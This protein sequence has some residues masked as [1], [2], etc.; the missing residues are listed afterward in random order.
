MDERTANKLI[1]E[2]NR[3]KNA[4]I[5]FAKTCDWFDFHSNAATLFEYL[6]SVELSLLKRKLHQAIE[7]IPAALVLAIVIFSSV[8]ITASPLLM[9][10]REQIVLIAAAAILFELLLLFE[11]RL[12]VNI[13]T[14]NQQKNKDRFIRHIE[15]DFKDQFGADTCNSG[16]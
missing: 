11:L 3:Y 10:Y 1:D 9:K 8:N 15:H 5:F 13:K 2:I 14:K 4:L 7:I 6:E 12:Y 16:T